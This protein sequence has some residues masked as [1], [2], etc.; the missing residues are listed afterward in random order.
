MPGNKLI[1]EFIGLANN[2]NQQVSVAHMVAPPHWTEEPQKPEFDE[3]TIMLRGQMHI[4]IAGES[5]VLGAGQVFMSKKGE[6]IRYSNPF[7][8]ENE[9]WA[10]CISAFSVERAGRKK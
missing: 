9:Y 10:I 3:I 7:N 8:E 2:G 4:E 5:V 6:E 1:E